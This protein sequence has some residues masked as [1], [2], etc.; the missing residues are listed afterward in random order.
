MIDEVRLT[1]M[2]LRDDEAPPRD[3]LKVLPLGEVA[4]AFLG[5]DDSATTSSSPRVR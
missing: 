2:A 4:G 1:F 3:E 5:L